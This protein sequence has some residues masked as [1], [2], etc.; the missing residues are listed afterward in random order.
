M[1]YTFGYTLYTSDNGNQYAIKMRSDVA[2]ILGA[3]LTETPAG[4]K[5]PNRE[6]DLR[7][8][9]A[10]GQTRGNRIRRLALTPTDTTWKTGLGANFT[11]TDAQA[12]TV[13]SSIGERRPLIG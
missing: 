1:A 2:S 10:K 12:Y 3:T 8:V 11:W 9:W 13:E 5:W 7:H 4:I 6:R